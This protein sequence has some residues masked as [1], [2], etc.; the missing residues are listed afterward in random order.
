VRNKKMEARKKGITPE[1]VD[2]ICKTSHQGIPPEVIQIGKRC[3]IDG[4]GV[5]LAGSTEWCSQIIREF[6][7]QAETSSQATTLG[8]GSRKTTVSMA[9]LANGTSGH[10]MDFDDTQLSRSPDRIYGLLTHPTI[11]PLCA[12]LAVGEQKEASGRAFL[13]SFLI[14]FE[15]ECKIAEAINPDHYKRGFHT[16]GTIGTFGAAAGAA[17]LLGLDGQQ[18]A[19][20]LGIA[21]SLSSGLRANFGT[22]TKPLHVGR[23]AQNGVTAAHLASLGFTSD[24]SSLDGPWGYFQIFGGGFDEEKISG[25]MGN[26]YTIVDPGV[27]VK[28]YP[29][30]VLSHPSMDALLDLVKEYEIQA[31][32]V[33]EIR[34]GAGSNILNP[35]RYQNPQTALEAKFSLP[36]CLASI[37]LDRKA[38]IRQ[39]RDEFVKSPRVQDMMKRVKTYLNPDIES[40]G[41]DRIL[42]IVEVKLKDGKTFNKESGPYRGSPQNPL[43]QGA[44]EQKFKECGELVLDG[45]K[46]SDALRL[47]NGIEDVGDLNELIH[48]LISDEG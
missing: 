22:M 27:S 29:S 14:G 5:I 18:T 4:F 34:L 11:P 7:D 17:K 25:R 13:E 47:I 2:F 6:I 37:V 43:T 10:A 19:C 30:G 12:T 38:G 48:M 41:Y 36:F 35:L 42:S 32:Q 15:V 3:L 45:G 8:R 23:A 16:S 40:R 9:A 21:A 39:F 28:P 46:I 1:I 20:A 31:E 24:S 26:P 44:L 33:D